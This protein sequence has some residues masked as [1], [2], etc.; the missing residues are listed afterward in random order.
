MAQASGRWY[1]ARRE[2]DGRFAAIFQADPDSG[3]SPDPEGCDEAHLFPS[4]TA[5]V[6]YTLRQFDG[7]DNVLVDESL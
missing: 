7:G 6:D 2:S 4:I 1:I 3:L 5:A